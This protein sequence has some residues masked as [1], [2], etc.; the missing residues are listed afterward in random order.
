MPAIH[1]VQDL[2][3]KKGVYGGMGFFTPRRKEC[4]QQD[5]WCHDAVYGETLMTIWILFCFQLLLS[6]FI[7]RFVEQEQERNYYT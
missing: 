7:S 1:G 4:V 6:L 2:L 5:Q 3:G